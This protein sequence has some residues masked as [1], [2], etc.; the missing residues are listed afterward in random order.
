MLSKGQP[1]FSMRLGRWPDTQH[2]AC[3][4]HPA[5]GIRRRVPIRLGASEEV[6]WRRGHF[7]SWGL[8][9]LRVVMEIIITMILPKTVTS[10]CCLPG[11]VLAALH[12]LRVVHLLVA[13]M[14]GA[15]NNTGGALQ[16]PVPQF[17]SL[18]WMDG[19]SSFMTWLCSPSRGRLGWAW[20]GSSRGECAR[21]GP[22]PCGHFQVGQPAAPRSWPVPLGWPHGWARWPLHWEVPSPGTRPS[23]SGPRARDPLPELVPTWTQQAAVP[24]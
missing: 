3:V 5:S 15:I 20:L 14:E 22:E 6:W 19:G 12:T 13:K 11:T 16:G 4:S 17:P 21:L 24:G 8:C 1:C 2:G 7:P 18:E 9:S 10:S 23:G